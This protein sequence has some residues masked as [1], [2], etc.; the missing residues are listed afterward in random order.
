[1][2]ITAYWREAF[3]KSQE[4]QLKLQAK[5]SELELQL[6]GYNRIEATKSQSPAFLGKRKKAAIEPTEASNSRHQKRTKTTKTTSTPST[7]DGALAVLTNEVESTETD[8]FGRPGLAE[9]KPL[10]TR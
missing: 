4:T 9:V 5:I 10:L 6:N 8:P 2:D 3:I 1:M 7:Q